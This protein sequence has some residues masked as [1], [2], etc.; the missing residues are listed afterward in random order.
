M[1][2]L[3][4]Y[5]NDDQDWAGHPKLRF[6]TNERNRPEVAEA[7]FELDRP[8]H[9]LAFRPAKITMHFYD[10]AGHEVRCDSEDWD[11]DLNAGLVRLGIQAVSPENEQER[12]ALALRTAFRRPVYRLGE[13]YF[14]SVLITHLQSSPFTGHSAIAEVLGQV[15]V[16]P[17]EMP[18]T[19]YRDCSEMIDLAIKGRARELLNDLHYPRDQAEEVLAGALAHYLDERFSVTN[20]RHL[21]RQA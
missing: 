10:R 19:A 18:S 9:G 7:R 11:D 21:G 20:R 16:S 15:I 5:F 17:P 3:D 12:F 6:W 14:N 1:S 13:G 8:R 4:A 2:G